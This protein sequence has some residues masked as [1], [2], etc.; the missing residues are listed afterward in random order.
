MV[1]II[2]LLKVIGF[3][4][5]FLVLL[6]LFFLGILLFLPICYECNGNGPPYTGN[7]KLKW[8]FGLIRIKLT[9]GENGFDYHLHIFHKSWPETKKTK[10]AKVKQNK[11]NQNKTNQNK[12]NQNQEIH[13]ESKDSN[14]KEETNFQDFFQ[15]KHFS[16]SKK[17]RRNMDVQKEKHKSILKKIKEVWK[18][19]QD[20]DNKALLKFGLKQLFFLLKKI[21]PHKIKANITFSTTDPATTGEILGALALIKWTYKNGVHIIADFTSEQYNLEGTIF[22]KGN[23]YGFYFFIVAIRF[24]KNKKIREM[25]FH[26]R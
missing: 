25:L 20:E 4:L 26:R 5:L 3:I 23:I 18:Q 7:A 6:I 8:L 9:F 2:G 14:S 1:F 10:K 21:K 22:I 15:K 11:T 19:I 12:T 16:F 13:E 17:K 24:L